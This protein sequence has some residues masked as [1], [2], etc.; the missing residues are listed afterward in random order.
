MSG[1]EVYGDLCHQVKEKRYCR[2][3]GTRL[4]KVLRLDPMYNEYTG[5]KIEFIAGLETC[6]NNA[7]P[8]NLR[9]IS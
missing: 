8:L 2:R 4:T 9:G 7:C 1:G 3:C 5:E 6:Q